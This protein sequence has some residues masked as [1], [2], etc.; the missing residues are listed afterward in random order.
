[1]FP[2]VR[3]RSMIALVVSAGVAVAACG[4]SATS[5]PSPSP[6]PPLDACLV[7]TWTV[8]GQTQNSPA[9]DEDITYS[10][11]T[12][13]VFTIE[14]NGGV[15]I[16]TH[17]ATTLVFESAGETFTAKVAGTGRGT[18][19]TATSGAHGVL[20]FKPSADD[21]RTTHSFDS[22]NTELGPAFPDF[23]FAAVYT[24]APGRFAFYKTAVNH[25]VDGPIVTHRSGAGSPP[26]TASPTP[27]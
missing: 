3:T 26:A 19:T 6:T 4:G 23:A 13:E 24:C 12:G 22:T 9:N 18:L 11:G 21:T 20:Y 15:T 5:S 17:A 1:M 27:S 2:R 14:A 8:V 10:G 25:M 16:D 7:G